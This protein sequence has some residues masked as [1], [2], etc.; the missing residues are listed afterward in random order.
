MRLK[1]ICTLE[2]VKLRK[3]YL[4]G[5]MMI[6]LLSWTATGLAYVKS[7]IPPEMALKML[8]E[9]N[10]RFAEATAKRPN[11]TL[12]R[13]IETADKGQK[14]FAVVLSCAD[15][16]VPVE[17]LFDRGIG[18]IFVVRDA[19]NIATATD[20]GSIEYA[21]DHLGT[22]LVVVMGHS[23]CGAVT[24][25]VEGGE[26]P[27]NIKAIIDFIAPA[28]TTAKSANADKTG[29]ALV[30]A[31]ITANVWQATADILKN[32]PLL[33]EKVKDGK[34]KLVGATYDI[35]SGR[36]NWLGPHPQQAQLVAGEAK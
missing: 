15:S 6:F 18:D 36:V 1:K 7:D 27:P 35:R 21:V 4:L 19:G 29:E 20:I 3:F 16:R 10:G 2:E 22:P 32:S 17:V 26:A 11:Q 9:G 8:Q 25:A 31:A 24:A 13:C 23:K 28:V 33:R 14:P 30:P 34:L 5:L 12:K